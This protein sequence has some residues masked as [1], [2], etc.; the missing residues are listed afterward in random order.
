VKKAKKVSRE[1]YLPPEGEKTN[2]NAN[3]AV[4]AKSYVVRQTVPQIEI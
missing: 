1:K 4:E 3:V 2:F